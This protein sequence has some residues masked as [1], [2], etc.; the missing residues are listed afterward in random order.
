MLAVDL[1]TLAQPVVILKLGL[2]SISKKITSIDLLLVNPEV[3]RTLRDLQ[4]LSFYE[5]KNFVFSN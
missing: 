3:A 2:R 4:L 5:K 1:A